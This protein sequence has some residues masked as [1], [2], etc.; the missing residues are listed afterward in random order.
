MS[1][2]YKKDKEVKLTPAKVFKLIK[3]IKDYRR[4]LGIN[5]KLTPNEQNPQIIK[6]LNME[7][8]MLNSIL[9]YRGVDNLIDVYTK[10]LTQVVFENIELKEKLK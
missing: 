10:K 1:K 5:N 4:Q 7:L 3:I 2:E 6:R 9:E 8:K